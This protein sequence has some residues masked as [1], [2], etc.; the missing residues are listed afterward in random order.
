MMI[1]DTTPI[2]KNKRKKDI[3]EEEKN[4]KKVKHN[5][6]SVDD[7]CKE[8]MN[9]NFSFKEIKKIKHFTMKKL[10]ELEINVSFKKI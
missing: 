9:T 2:Q 1:D 3:N 4:K 6:V 8:L 5:N 7:I 10:Y